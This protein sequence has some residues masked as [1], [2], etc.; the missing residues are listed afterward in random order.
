MEVT[1]C[2]RQ[3]AKLVKHLICS[4]DLIQPP[5]WFSPKIFFTH[6]Q[7]KKSFARALSSYLPRSST[8]LLDVY[9]D[10]TRITLCRLKIVY[11]ATSLHLSV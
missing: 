2:L 3:S 4:T 10:F 1:I 8:S 6:C 5:G 11:H 7:G 9:A